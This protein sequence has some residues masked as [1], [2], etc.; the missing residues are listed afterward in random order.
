MKVRNAPAEVRR[1]G[2]DG[3][4]AAAV[5]VSTTKPVAME[6]AAPNERK[7]FL[8][9]SSHD[10]P[11]LR[12]AEIFLPGL[13]KRTRFMLWS[14]VMSAVPR[15][16]QSRNGQS[17]EQTKGNTQKTSRSTSAIVAAHRAHTRGSIAIAR[18]SPHFFLSSLLPV[19][20]LAGARAST[21]SVALTRV[22]LRRTSGR[23]GESQ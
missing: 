14:H 23:P 3:N 22:R 6:V 9:E 5:A 17:G 7:N 10:R 20:G 4:F 19:S 15:S 12:S 8:L 13:C 2:T 11:A 1:T 18:R 16:D 21:G